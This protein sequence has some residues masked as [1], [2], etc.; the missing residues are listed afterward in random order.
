[1]GASGSGWQGPK[2]EIVEDCLVL[3]I[4][5]L[6]RAGLLKT[7]WPS[8]LWGW[9]SGVETVATVKLDLSMYA[10]KG[11]IWLTY[12]A[13]GQSM[14]YTVSLVTT[15]PNYGGR[16]W[17]FVCPLTKARASKLYL[18]PNATTFASRQAY[19]L[20]YRSCRESGWRKRSE[21]LWRRVSQRLARD[22]PEL[23][24]FRK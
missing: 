14:Q 4:K 9:G 7:G 17:W 19:D 20:T 1:M 8:V 12:T 2:K 15:A 5:E 11:T 10:E 22:E 24:A 16:R 13:N 21:K 6:A 18:P 3:S 23:R